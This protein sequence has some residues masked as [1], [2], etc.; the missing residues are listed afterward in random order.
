MGK[1]ELATGKREPKVIYGFGNRENLQRAFPDSLTGQADN[2]F[3]S[4]QAQFATSPVG[5]GLDV[6]EGSEAKDQ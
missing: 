1:R 5:H 2:G 4:V 6:D 3:L